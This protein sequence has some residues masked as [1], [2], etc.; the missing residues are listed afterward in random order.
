MYRQLARRP[1]PW[2]VACAEEFATIVSQQ[3]GR[4]IAPHEILFDAPPTKLEIQFDIEVH[5]VRDSVYRPL[6]EVSPVVQTLAKQQFDDF[7]K[8]VRI[9]AHPEIVPDVESL[10]DLEPLLQ[11]AID[12]TDG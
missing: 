6:G 8:R 5:F 2:L 9:F 7:V 12:R 10:G 4:R 11:Q 3:S 1:Y